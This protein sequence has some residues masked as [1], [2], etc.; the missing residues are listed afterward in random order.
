MIT[1]MLTSWPPQAARPAL[2]AQVHPASKALL[3]CSSTRLEGVPEGLH[4]HR[5]PMREG[6]VDGVDYVFVSRQQFE[7]WIRDDELV[8]HALV[9]GEYKGIP[10]GH[11]T[12]ALAAGSDVVLR[13]DVQG[14]A[15]IKRMIPRAILVFI[16]RPPLPPPLPFPW[17][18]GSSLRPAEVVQM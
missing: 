3:T 11:I 15:T 1:G 4:V 5:R 6:E 12:S 16:V 10:R 18:P 13:V 14:A 9:Y 8:E 7:Q 2:S 17:P